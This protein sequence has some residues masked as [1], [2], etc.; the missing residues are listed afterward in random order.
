MKSATPALPKETVA[1][2]AGNLTQPQS[3]ALA[4]GIQ[5]REAQSISVA[6][7]AAKRDRRDEKSAIDR[8]L[9]SCCRESLAAV[10]QY[11]FARGG[12]DIDGPSIRLLEAIAQCWGNLQSGWAEIDRYIGQDGVGVSVIEAFA[13]DLE[14]NYRVPRIF[15]VRHWRDTKQ[16]G[17]PLKD[18]R[19]IYELCA[20]TAARRVRA[21]L[22][23]VIPGDVVDEARK[24]C[25][26]TLASKTDVSPEAMQKMLAAFDA[27][28]VTKAQI[29]ERIQRRIEAITPA[30]VVT[31]RK[32]Y[33]S[34]RDG[35]SSVSDW[36]ASKAA[37][38]GAQAAEKETIDPF[39]GAANNTAPEPQEQPVA[40]TTE[41]DNLI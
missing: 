38:A 23:A 7:M 20:N 25:D 34:L 10:A 17:Y 32:V 28:G 13:W 8:I 29:E 11:Q 41:E 1:E 14:S 22:I 33:N 40:A 39:A 18:E 37:A 4:Q 16:G 27:I 12:T 35:M 36:F 5:S 15:N 24:Q 31:L 19:D 26:A 6:M 2:L 9:N 30:Q 3:R 21:C